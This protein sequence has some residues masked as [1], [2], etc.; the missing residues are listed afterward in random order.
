MKTLIYNWFIISFMCLIAL[1]AHAQ[2][3]TDVASNKI[4]LHGDVSGVKDSIKYVYANLL[5][6]ET[7][8]AKVI[9]GKYHFEWTTNVPLFITLMC[10]SPNVFAKDTYASK[11]ITVFMAEPS[12]ILVSSIDSFSNLKIT[13]SKAYIEWSNVETSQAAFRKQLSILLKKSARYQSGTNNNDDAYKLN[14]EI[15]SIENT[16]RELVNKKEN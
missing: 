10:K 7:D 8:S 15:D 16:F 3:K 12:N 4:I 5:N 13:G 2:S 9:N 14:L 11:N 1:S 6:K